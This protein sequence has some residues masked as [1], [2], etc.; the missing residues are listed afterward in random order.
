MRIVIIGGSGHVGTFLVPR[1]VRLGYELINISRGKSRPYHEDAAWQSV[2]QVHLDRTAEEAR[3]TFGVHVRELNA[4]VVIDMT[5]FTI[6]SA[7]Q[8]VEALRGHVQQFVHCGT[9]WVHGYPVRTPLTEDDPRRPFG[10]YGIRKC[11][12]EQYL[13]D[14]ARRHGFPATVLHPGH[15][16]GPGWTMVGPTACHDTSPFDKLSRGNELVLPNLGMETVHHVHAD[17]VAQAFEKA[18]THGSAAVGESFL[19]VSDAALTLRGFA[20]AAAGW[21]GQQANL[22]FAPMPQ[23]LETLPQRFRDSATAHLEHSTNCSCAKA[24]RL[25]DYHPRYTSL[26]AVK[27]SLDRLPANAADR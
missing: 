6:D 13:L 26:Q 18:I 5:C 3:G 2:R 20:E 24:M 15:I 23:F 27:E 8:V 11:Q 22:K 12:V 17:D 14:Q 25:L 7:K 10:D 19:V 1:L 16:T 4:D 9:V 21:F